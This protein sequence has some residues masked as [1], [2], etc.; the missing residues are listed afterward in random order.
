MMNNI[1]YYNPNYYYYYP[2]NYNTN[3]YYQPL[4]NNYN[5]N[6]NTNFNTNTFYNNS[7]NRIDNNNRSN[8]FTNNGRNYNRKTICDVCNV[9]FN[10]EKQLLDHIN[11]LH[12][13]C[14]YENCNFSAPLSILEIHK[15]K[16][17]KNEEGKTIDSKDEIK[18]WINSRI[19]NFPKHNSSDSTTIDLTSQENKGKI[20]N[21]PSKDNIINKD[22]IVSKEELNNGE[23]NGK[24]PELEEMSILERYLRSKMNNGRF[25]ERNSKKSIVFPYLNKI[26]KQ[27]SALVRYTNPVKYEQMLKRLESVK[28]PYSYK[29]SI[30]EINKFK[31]GVR[32]NIY[33]VPIRPP[34]VLQLIRSDVE[35]LDNSVVNIIKY[36]V[37]NNFL[38]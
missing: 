34:A 35:K 14:N 5:Y 11:D 24:G 21:S 23:I 9:Y 6:I 10:N 28:S 32:R 16:H 20:F 33:S 29:S 36:I 27:P 38:N 4:Y 31:N 19:K 26:Y 22:G 30:Y 17:V 18:K 8:N 12:I 15:L 3:Y 2:P 7:S 37:N 1:N 13:T 25:D